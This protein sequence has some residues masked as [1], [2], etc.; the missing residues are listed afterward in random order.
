MATA[1]LRAAVSLERAD[2]RTGKRRRRDAEY[3]N[4]QNE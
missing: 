2:R 3:A 1:T 4:P